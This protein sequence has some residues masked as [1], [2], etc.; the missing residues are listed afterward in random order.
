MLEAAAV[1]GGFCVCGRYFGCNS[2]GHSDFSAGFD[3]WCRGLSRLDCFWSS[4][5]SRFGFWCGGFG[6]AGGSGFRR[7]DF[8]GC[9]GG[10]A[11]SG[12]GAF[13]QVSSL[14]DQTDDD[15]FVGAER[16]LAD[17]LDDG[18]HAQGDEDAGIERTRT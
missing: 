9:W 10:R 11:S 12:G 1:G 7:G 2:F 8:S 6:G 4:E 14:W 17:E 13:E 18:P 5:V 3:C 15:F 16:V